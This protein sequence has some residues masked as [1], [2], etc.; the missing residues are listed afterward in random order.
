MSNLDSV[1]VEDLD[2]L[3]DDDQRA[4]VNDA[5]E[6]I[7]KRTVYDEER[8]EQNVMSIADQDEAAIATFGEDSNA[9][10]FFKSCLNDFD[11]IPE[12]PRSVPQA[13]SRIHRS[14]SGVSNES[15][16]KS[17][18]D[19]TSNSSSEFS[20]NSVFNASAAAAAMNSRETRS[21]SRQSA[22]ASPPAIQT[23]IRSLSEN[24]VL[25]ASVAAAAMNSRE[26]RSKSRPS[27][28]AS[29]PAI[30]TS[31]RSSSRKTSPRPEIVEPAKTNK[32][33]T[34]KTQK[35]L[36]RLGATGEKVDVNAPRATRTRKQS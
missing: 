31:I 1:D 18:T 9:F 4:T 27:A 32:T 6:D 34:S 21:K 12:A 33:P 26:T 7:M 14:S 8:H 16:P 17:R 19:R 5:P 2:D 15:S 29:P 3:M 36:N 35:E 10:K 22:A 28:A 23:P 24:S 13:T 30:Q 25:N 11:N 20:E